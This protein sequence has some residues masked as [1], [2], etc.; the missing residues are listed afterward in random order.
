[1]QEKDLAMLAQ[2]KREVVAGLSQAPQKTLPSKYFYDQRG[3]ELFRQIMALPEYYLTR[4]EMDIFS[5]K[6]HELLAA[7]QAD[8][9]QSCEIV[10]LGAGD[11]TK[12]CELLTVMRNEGY[13]VDYVPIDIS[14]HALDKL[15]STFRT[16][17]PALRVLPKQD[18]Y[19]SALRALQHDGRPKII[20]FLGSNIGNLLDDQ[21]ADFL[22]Q[23]GANLQRGDK[24]LLG[25]DLIKPREI[26][27]PAYADAQ[28]VTRE[29]NLNLLDRINRELAGNF[30]RE[31]FDHVATYD[32]SEGIARSY[33]RSKTTQRV[34][35]AAAAAEFTFAA[36]ET[37]H[38]ESSRKYNDE[39][40]GKILTTTDF[41]IA[42]KVL[43]SN[44]YFADYVLVRN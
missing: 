32:A 37:I 29:F 13:E 28:G 42:A 21:A 25:V 35:I 8:Q 3:D 23:L 14:Q 30:V 7:L 5:N 24:I 27:L 20:L 16:K 19:F 41:T 17:L 38:T 12:T 40:L 6:A 2:F 36:D 15:Q 22:F 33:L 11:G 4:A 26:V 1:M 10:E 44:S 39:I 9:G 18:D 31:Q 34:T 43:D